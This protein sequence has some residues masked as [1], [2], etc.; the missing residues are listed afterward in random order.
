MQLIEH[1][2]YGKGRVQN[3]RFGGF[4]LY[5]KFED[6]I[7][8]W[9]RRDDIRLL[10]NT[11]VLVKHNPVEHILSIE[12]FKA[13]Q[14]IEALRLGVVPHKY[15]EE[16]MFGR[17]EE[18]R[19]FKKWLDNP[20]NNIVTV[21]GEYGAGKTHFLEYIY[22]FALANNWAVSIVEIDPSE[23]SLYKPKAVYQKIISSF[24]FRHQDGNF[25][26]F[27][28]QIANH[29]DFYKINQHKY[30]SHMVKKIRNSEDDEDVWGWIEGQPTWY[31]YLPMYEQAT[32]VNIYSY[33][34][35]G[36]GWAAKNILDLNGF[37]I[38]FDEAESIDPYWYSSY[39]NNKTWNFLTGVILMANNDENLL[40]EVQENKFYEHRVYGGW[41]GQ[42]TNLQYCGY[43]RIPFTWRIPC[44]VKT[45]FT[46]TP[47][48]WILDREPLC[49]VDKLEIEY[50]DNGSLMKISEKIASLYQEAYNFRANRS[51][52]DFIPKDKTRLFVKGMIE[53][54]DLMRF[55]Y[56]KPI[57]TLLK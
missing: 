11:S 37:L 19:Q 49:N 34:L 23:A 42:Y 41:W 51:Y 48:S 46:F 15:V 30:L 56:N 40:K 50:L 55:H 32:C 13:R 24:K 54:L 57:E 18:I 21:V 17:K 7:S 35:S 43:S 2:I 8:R 38:L 6:G 16:F 47:V 9:V 39:Q 29:P 14:I 12:Q 33:I 20:N 5:V 3:K 10:S 25:R 4:E 45:V 1:R 22:S 27:L 52:F 36:I 44:Y 53:A 31:R 26:T 28:K